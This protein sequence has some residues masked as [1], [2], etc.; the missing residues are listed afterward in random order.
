M[1]SWKDDVTN[2]TRMDENRIA[3]QDFQ[4]LHNTLVMRKDV[5]KSKFLDVNVKIS[6]SL[7]SVLLT[8]EDA[9]S[10]DTSIK[11]GPKFKKL[12]L[13]CNTEHLLT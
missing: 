12:V 6:E 9:F 5:E 4:N 11:M 7:G 8:D 2:V 13:I 1:F 10:T 3:E